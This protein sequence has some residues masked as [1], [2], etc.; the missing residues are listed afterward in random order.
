MVCMNGYIALGANTTSCERSAAAINA[1]SSM[2]PRVA[3]MLTNLYSDGPS[4]TGEG[5]CSITWQGSKVWSGSS[6]SGS[7]DVD[8]LV[9][10]STA[11]PSAASFTSSA[12][13]VAT[14]QN[15]EYYVNPYYNEYD[16]RDTYFCARYTFQLVLTRSSSGQAYLIMLYSNMPDVVEFFPTIA[17]LRG[18]SSWLSMYDSEADASQRSPATALGQGTNAGRAGLWVYRVDGTQIEPAPPSPPSPPP[19]RKQLADVSW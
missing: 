15:V 5:Y 13:F 8:A 4:V 16:T 6:S 14:W 19:P 1:A 10:Q 17:G 2:Y 11:I 9:R 3:L 7:G 18:A 12:Y